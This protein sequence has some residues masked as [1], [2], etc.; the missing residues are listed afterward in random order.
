MPNTSW[1]ADDWNPEFYRYE[2]IADWIGERIETG[3]YR[4]R[5]VL[6]E[7]QLQNYFG[8]GRATIRKAFAILRDRGLII[9]KPGRGSVVLHRGD[10]AGS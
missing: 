4:P 6:S 1:N 2:Q 7:I 10:E 3:V 5:T 8:V 9:T